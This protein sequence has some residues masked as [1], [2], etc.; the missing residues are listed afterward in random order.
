MISWLCLSAANHPDRSEVPLLMYARDINP[1][2]R[3]VDVARLL[4]TSLRVRFGLDVVPDVL[5]AAIA[6]GEASL[7]VDGL[8]EVPS[9]ARRQFSAAIDAFAAQHPQTSILITTRPFGGL[10]AE[11]P[12][13]ERAELGTWSPA[14][15]D[16]YA[17]NLGV[18]A[19]L[20]Q[21][22]SNDELVRVLQETGK[23]TTFGTPLL[24][25]ML[26]GYLTTHRYGPSPDIQ[27][28][29]V[30]SLVG[31]IV[32]GLLLDREVLRIRDTVGAERLRNVLERLA[33][34][35]Q[36]SSSDR[37]TI[38]AARARAAVASFESADLTLDSLMWAIDQYADRDV[39]LTRLRAEDEDVRYAF[40]HSL[41]QE[42]LASTYAPRTQRKAQP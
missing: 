12:G 42:Y 2:E 31:S 5:S 27:K 14:L 18:A 6:Q 11:L 13:F 30:T 1:D 40:V 33:Y 35:M 7:V 21:P 10:D 16:Q 9:D 26:L 23:Y 38:T 25:Q 28:L 8:D 15:I 32:G 19:G 39:L 3:I 34:V 41:Y 22:G 29:D 37:V 17:A 36:T 4:A 20:D 24:Q